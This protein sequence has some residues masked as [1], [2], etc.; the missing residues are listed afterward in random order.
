MKK[1]ILIMVLALAAGAAAFSLRGRA[2]ATAAAYQT[3]S[4]TRGEMSARVTCSGTLAPVATVDVGA[5]VS[6]AI[7]ALYADYNSRVQAGQVIA[8]IDPALFAAKVAQTRGA[9]QQAVANLDKARVALADAERTLARN[10]ALQA[11]GTIAQSELDT[12]QTARDTARAG[13]AAALGSV[14]QT[15]GALAEAQANLGYTVITSPVNGTV[16]NRKVSVGQTVAASLQ[17]PTLFSIAQ[18]LT[19]MEI[20]ASVDESDIG[21]VREGQTAAFT[22][23]A[24]PERQFAG[25]VVQVRNAAVT[26]SNVVTYVAVVEVDNSGLLLK[27]G[28]T[29]NVAFEVARRES[30]LKVPAAAL[31]FRPAGEKAPAGSRVY[32]LGEN[33]TLRPVEVVAGIASGQEVEITAGSLAE[34]DRVVLHEAAAADAK[35]SSGMRP[36]FG[37]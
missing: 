5:Q 37:F 20:D 32:V 6:G 7:Q 10:R 16:I 28:M 21:S 4:P 17:T 29:A 35:Q 9:H 33:G 36:P 31:R 13:V 23:D 25:R 8:R 19:R 18:D 3:A 34:T 11:D 15:R 24:Y 22:V 12:A 2:R 14:E 1:W 26:V 27:P 30:A